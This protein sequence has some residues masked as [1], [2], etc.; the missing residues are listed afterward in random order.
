MIIKIIQQ[1]Y[2]NS[3]LLIIG[4]FFEELEKNK[5]EEISTID[6]KR[7]KQEEIYYAEQLK[8]NKLKVAEQNNAKQKV[9][10]KKI[11]DDLS[12]FCKKEILPNL[13]G[14]GS[15]SKL[16]FYQ[17]FGTKLRKIKGNL[18]DYL[19]CYNIELAQSDLDK[20]YEELLNKLKVQIIKIYCN[21]PNGKNHM[22]Y[23]FLE[24]RPKCS[25]YY[26]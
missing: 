1:E 8:I 26:T 4:F 10:Y 23:C 20:N 16:K 25:P 3:F 7:R 14:K 11:C 17:L 19:N 13:L 22:P 24:T 15:Y 5:I 6:L 21:E 12:L 18:K 9:F 2:L